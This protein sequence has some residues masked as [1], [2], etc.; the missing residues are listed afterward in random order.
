MPT[1]DQTKG[2]RT[3]NTSFLSNK[4][5]DHRKTPE[6]F[7]IGSFGNQGNPL[8]QEKNLNTSYQND[9]EIKKLTYLKDLYCPNNKA[10]TAIKQQYQN[11]ELT[12]NVESKIRKDCSSP[13]RKTYDFGPTDEPLRTSG[14][15]SQQ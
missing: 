7:S 13:L 10:G 6:P 1:T 4:Y 9:Q 5:E 3:H 8:S 11:V 14:V 15:E 12:P 2:M